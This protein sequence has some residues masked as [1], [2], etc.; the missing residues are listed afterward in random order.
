MTSNPH[1][2]FDVRHRVHMEVRDASPWHSPQRTSHHQRCHRR[3]LRSSSSLHFS[4]GAWALEP[5]AS[6][7]ATP[8]R[9]TTANL[10]VW[11]NTMGNGAAGSVYYNLNLTNLSAGTCTLY[12]YPGV[13]A[14]TQAGIQLGSA[15]GRDAAHAVTLRSRSPARA[16]ARGLETSTS[17]NTAT[18]HSSDHR[19]RELPPVDL[20][21][22]HRGGPARL[23]AQPK[24]VDGR[25]VSLR[26]LRQVRTAISSRRGRTALRQYAIDLYFL[27]DTCYIV[28]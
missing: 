21:A 24:R 1:R 19:R 2:G 9:C 20:R 17:H 10:D 11:L 26:R 6:S 4:P 7:A 14:V 13:S 27:S 16:R 3:P 5:L 12:G 28:H 25:A 23:S 8:S 15:A 22:D 18:D